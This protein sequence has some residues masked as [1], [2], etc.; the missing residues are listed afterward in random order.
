MKAYS[1]MED[2]RRRIDLNYQFIKELEKSLDACE[3]DEE[4]LE[5]LQLIGCGCSEYITGAYS[6]NILEREIVKIG[7]IIEFSPEEKPQNGKI[8]HVMTRAG[9]A[10]GHS[11][12]V[13]NWIK[14]DKKRQYSIVFTDMEY[15]D[16][17]KFI[18][19]SVEKT[20]G[21]IL[22][23]HGNFLEK[24]KQLLQFSQKFERIVLHIHMYDIVPLLAYSNKNWQI[25]V[26]FYNH[27][28]FRF[29][30]GFSVADVVLNLNKFDWEKSKKY[31]GIADEKNL[32]LQSPN[33]GIIDSVICD[34]ETKEKVL[35]NFKIDKKRKLIVSMGD[36]FK[37]QDIIH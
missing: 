33:G 6:S 17:P 20:G 21:T 4:K 22:C 31:R 1:C 5:L 3:G 29:S 26:Y 19:Q 8:L 16:I 25:P 30:Y 10:G 11:T 34:E 15:W 28:D 13:Y 12:I 32:I 2:V 35:L 24:A 23:L 9:K 37:Y 27:A 18:L 7:Q 36:E 14:N